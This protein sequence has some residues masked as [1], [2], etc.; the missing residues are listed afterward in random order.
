MGARVALQ[1]PN[2]ARLAPRGR[3]G[4]REGRTQTASTE[5]AAMRLSALGGAKEVAALRAKYRVLARSQGSFHI[6]AEARAVLTRRS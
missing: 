4:R 5:I 1:D 2:V 3:R 6:I